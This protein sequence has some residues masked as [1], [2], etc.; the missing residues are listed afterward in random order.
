MQFLT[1]AFNIFESVNVNKN[2]K[3]LVIKRAENEEN[4]KDE[5]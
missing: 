1:A 2:L 5:K 3:V 4:D